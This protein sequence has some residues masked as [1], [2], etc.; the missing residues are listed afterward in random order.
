MYFVHSR[1]TI[2]VPYSVGG[3]GC[4]MVL[5]CCGGCWMRPCHNISKVCVCVFLEITMR[6][7]FNKCISNTNMYLDKITLLLFTID[8]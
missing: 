3:S 1:S 6:I 4:W 2:T 7:S 5:T 8:A